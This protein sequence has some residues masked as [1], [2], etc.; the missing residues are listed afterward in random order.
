MLKRILVLALLPIL[1]M[2]CIPQEQEPIDQE[3][4]VATFTMED[5]SIFKVELYPDTAPNTV[6]NFIELAQAGFYDGLIFHRVIPG[7]IIQ[8][9]C[10]Q[11]SGTGGPGY[12]I[13]GEFA[14]NAFENH[15]SHQKGVIS[16]ARVP[17]NPDSAG[18]QFFIAVGDAPHLDGDYAAFGQVIS[19]LETAEKISLVE[20]DEDD[21]PLAPQR[22]KSVSINTFGRSYQPAEKIGR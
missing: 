5:G 22:I 10:P 3:N 17:N 15:L 11:G 8:G 2:G 13:K 20:K 16:M 9:G 14:A 19:G 7:Y 12:S 1:L 21:R 18:S 6:R 4:P